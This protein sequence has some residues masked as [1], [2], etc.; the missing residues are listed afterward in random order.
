M[1][2]PHHLIFYRPDALPDAQLTMSEQKLEKIKVE[3]VEI[4]VIMVA[5]AVAAVLL[6]RDTTKTNVLNA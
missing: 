3:V 6:I 4:V 2:A 5:V 1:P